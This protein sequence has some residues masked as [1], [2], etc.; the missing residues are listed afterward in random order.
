MTGWQMEGRLD[1]RGAKDGRRGLR[2]VGGSEAFGLR[3]M[4][5]K[6]GRTAQG[7]DSYFLGKNFQVSLV[8]AG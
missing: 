1:R 3:S 5:G 2:K 7:R 8:N 4:E 6:K